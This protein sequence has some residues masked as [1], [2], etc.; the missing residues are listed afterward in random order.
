MYPVLTG[1]K[2]ELSSREYL[3]YYAYIHFV[4]NGRKPSS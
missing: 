4:L 1:L 2:T 3:M